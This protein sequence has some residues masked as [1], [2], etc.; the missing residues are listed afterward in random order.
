MK[1][2]K[3]INWVH[4]AGLFGQQLNQI[5][6]TQY[7]EGSS[8]FIL[9]ISSILHY[10]KFLLKNTNMKSYTI[11]V[12]LLV[13]IYSFGQNVGIN[14]TNPSERLH[15]LDNATTKLLLKTTNGT[16]FFTTDSPS[17][18]GLLFRS[19][20]TDR[21]F[22]LYSPFSNSLSA[23]IGSSGWT[24]F[25]NG[26][27]RVKER[28]YALNDLRLDAQESITIEA[29]GAL[30]KIDPD[31][32]ILIEGNSISINAQQ[33]LNLNANNIN[34]TAQ[35][36][37][38]V[39]SGGSAMLSVQDALQI[40]TG[41]HTSLDAGSNINVTATTNLNVNAG[42]DISTQ[43]NNLDVATVKATMITSGTDIGVSSNNLALSVGEDA[44]VSIA[45]NLDASIGNNCALTIGLNY[46][47]SIAGSYTS[48]INNN[49]SLSAIGI[50]IQAS[51]LT[52]IK[53]SSIKFNNGGTPFARVG[54][55]VIV[56]GK[57]GSITTGSSE[58]VGN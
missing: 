48:S 33:D 23:S 1:D 2:Q 24:M 44:V 8:S 43:S 21:A 10:L 32:N 18:S 17:N 29:N 4:T 50:N 40:N 38:Q 15:I 25:S 54:D 16:S 14:I 46:S 26:D 13:S 35:N 55:T 11:F 30:I 6:Q 3:Y 5:N 27:I 7:M 12:L 28:I 52:N 9:F 49:Y 34:M 45:D 37:L 19:S 51:A 22:L 41:G 39:S 56:G 42:N 53:G 57:V 36:N 58:V 31:G 47:S 20:G